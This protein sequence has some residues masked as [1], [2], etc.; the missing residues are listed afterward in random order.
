MQVKQMISNFVGISKNG[1]ILKMGWV[2]ILKKN[3]KEAYNKKAGLTSKNLSLL[4]SI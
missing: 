1:E 3:Q 2:Y 4:N